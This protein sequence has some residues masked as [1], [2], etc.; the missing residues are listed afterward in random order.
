MF[1]KGKGAI[2][3]GTLNMKVSR[4]TKKTHFGG[5]KVRDPHLTLPLLHG[6]RYC[7]THIDLPAQLG[8]NI[9]GRFLPRGA[10]VREE[11]PFLL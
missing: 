6:G 9:H 1:F 11:T 10:C 5:V 8:Y 3:D 7:R 2:V 4:W